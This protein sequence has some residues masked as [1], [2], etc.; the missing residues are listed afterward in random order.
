MADTCDKKHVRADECSLY[1]TMRSSA[2][3][4]DLWR[5]SEA[6]P[7]KGGVNFHEELNEAARNSVLAERSRWRGE[8]KPGRYKS[9]PD[10]FGNDLS[11]D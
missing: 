5:Y 11:V 9:Y 4:L 3:K 6:H 1:R 7:P 8:A 10:G 2:G